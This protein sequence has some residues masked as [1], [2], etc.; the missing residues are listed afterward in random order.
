M[1]APGP[2][3]PRTVI[4]G[5]PWSPGR[6]PK[7]IVRPLFGVAAHAAGRRR[8]PSG[9]A[10]VVTSRHNAMS[11]FLAKATIMVLRVPPRASAVRSRYHRARALST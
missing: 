6:A 4:G 3:S 9:G 7:L 11:N 10:P 1:L 8:T 5:P 2:P